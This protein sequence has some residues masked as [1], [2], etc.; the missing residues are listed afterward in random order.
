MSARHRSHHQSPGSRV[1]CT[2]VR[3]ML[4]RKHRVNRREHCYSSTL[5]SLD[6]SR[7]LAHA[8]GSRLDSVSASFAPAR[9][10]TS[11]RRHH[12]VS[13]HHLLPGRTSD[14]YS[15]EVSSVMLMQNASTFAVG[16]CTNQ[17]DS[18]ALT[19]LPL[20]PVVQRINMPGSPFSPFA[21]SHSYEA[22][23]DAYGQQRLWRTG[24]YGG[25]RTHSNGSSGSNSGGRSD[26]PDPNPPTEGG[27]EAT[28]GEQPGDY[29]FRRRNAIVEGSDDAPKADDFSRG[30]P[31]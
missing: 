25:A 29:T 9:Q 24:H 11:Q 1:H 3:R 8:I 6:S 27:G 23:E 21:P 2:R 7:T 16:C 13:N 10:L 4:V 5:D 30:S 17:D 20:P 26:G 22:M 31:Q 18:L 28:E 14:R 12:L 19:S 15:D